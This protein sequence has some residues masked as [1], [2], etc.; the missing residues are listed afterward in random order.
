MNVCEQMIII[1]V[2]AQLVRAS[3]YQPM[4]SGSNLDLTICIIYLVPVAE[5]QGQI[6]KD[7][8][9]IIVLAV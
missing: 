1:K 2:I 8:R 9:S 5:W 7:T 4:G 6:N 3:D